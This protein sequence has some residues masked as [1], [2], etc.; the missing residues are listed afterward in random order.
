MPNGGRRV[1]HARGVLR[2]FFTHSANPASRAGRQLRLRCALA[3]SSDKNPRTGQRRS[4]IPYS[5]V[6]SVSASAWE[7]E[8]RIGGVD[9]RSGSPRSVPPSACVPFCRPDPTQGT[10]SRVAP[11]WYAYDNC[12]ADLPRRFDRTFFISTDTWQEVV[13]ALVSL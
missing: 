3:Q 11:S 7:A 13:Y 2:V 6:I 1:L 9:G 5:S 8:S 4:V 10:A 12:Q